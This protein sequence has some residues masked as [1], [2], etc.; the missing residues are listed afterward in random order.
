MLSSRGWPLPRSIVSV[1]AG[2][3]FAPYSSISW[4]CFLRTLSLLPSIGYFG[5]SL[6]VC[7]S[8]KARCW[9]FFFL[10]FTSFQN[11]EHPPKEA[12]EFFGFWLFCMSC[13]PR[14]WSIFY[15][16]KSLE[17]GFAQ[18]VPLWAIG[19]AVGLGMNDP[20]LTCLLSHMT[21][22][23]FPELTKWFDLS[24]LNLVFIE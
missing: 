21:K 1:G 16:S 6:F 20:H 11:N 9:F 15:I 23:Y 5:Y 13:E 4:K 3:S 19:V 24:Y 10:L 12:K 7:L 22:S 17:P 18:I 8:E 14:N 2:M